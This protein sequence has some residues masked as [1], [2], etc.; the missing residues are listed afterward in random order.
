MSDVHYRWRRRRRIAYNYSA[1][2]GE[3]ITPAEMYGDLW[4]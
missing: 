1:T 3:Y 2:E 4:K